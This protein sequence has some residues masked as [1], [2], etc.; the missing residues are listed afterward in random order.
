MA[1]TILASPI[2]NDGKYNAIRGSFSTDQPC[3]RRWFASV[4]CNKVNFCKAVSWNFRKIIHLPDHSVTQYLIN[5][6][7]MPLKFFAQL[8]RLRHTI[9]GSL[10]RHGA[11]NEFV[12]DWEELKKHRGAGSGDRFSQ[13]V[14]D[15]PLRAL[16]VY[17][18]R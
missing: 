4:N 15:I 9:R 14:H 2:A 17:L 11:V 8:S 18:D 10:F 6:E 1:L 13:A 3:H 7:V 12:V 16:G 5:I